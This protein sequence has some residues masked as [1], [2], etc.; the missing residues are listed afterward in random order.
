MSYQPCSSY[1]PI[2][3]HG[4]VARRQ[5]LAAQLDDTDAA[6]QHHIAVLV[7]DARL[8]VLQQRAQR[9]EPAGVALGGGHGAAQRGQHAIGVS[10][11]PTGRT[12]NI[13][14]QKRHHP[15]R[16]SRRHGIASAH[17][18]CPSKPSDLAIA[19]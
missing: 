8:Q 15:R 17:F 18:I 11:P 5:R 10:F 16:S 3:C 7:D 19:R 12:L 4:D 6:R 9:G 1:A 13:G 14:E 2:S